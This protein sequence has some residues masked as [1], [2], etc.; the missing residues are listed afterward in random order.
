VNSHQLQSDKVNQ[1]YVARLY[2]EVL[3]CSEPVAEIMPERDA[4]FATGVHQAEEGIATIASYITVSAATDL[5]L[6][7]VT[8]NVSLGVIGVQRYRR[9]VEHG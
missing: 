4:E 8:A 9:P 7:D 3:R 5:A 2:G 6:N 1:L